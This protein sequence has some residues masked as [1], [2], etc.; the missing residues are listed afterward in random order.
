[1]LLRSIAIALGLVVTPLA[2]SA[3]MIY[4][5]RPAPPG[6]PAGLRDPALPPRLTDPA[7]PPHF[8]TRPPPFFRHR[9]HFFPFFPF[10]GPVVVFG[11]GFTTCEVAARAVH[12]SPPTATGSHD[13]VIAYVEEAEDATSLL[14]GLR[15]AGYPDVQLVSL[16]FDPRTRYRAEFRLGRRNAS[17][18]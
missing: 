9:R 8:G 15:A 13:V 6:P 12:D 4:T 2:A 18:C 10:F 5:Q 17:L 7:L 3:Q 16:Q 14:Y 11:D 1:M